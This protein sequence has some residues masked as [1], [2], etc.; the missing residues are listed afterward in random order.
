MGVN[1]EKPKRIRVAI[2]DNGSL[3]NAWTNGGITASAYEGV[4]A[5][6]TSS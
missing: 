2:K 3:T 4:L 6:I 1:E 5:Y